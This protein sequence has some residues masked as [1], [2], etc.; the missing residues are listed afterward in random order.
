MK[1][2]ALF[3]LLFTSL[4]FA[5]QSGDVKSS[6][7]VK[8]EVKT[9]DTQSKSE[10]SSEAIVSDEIVMDEVSSEDEIIMDEVSSED[11]IIM[12]EVSSEDEII[13]DEVSSEDDSEGDSEGEGEENPIE[14]MPEQT[15]FVEAV[16]PKEIYSAGVEGSVILEL[17]VNDSGVVDSANVVGSLEPTLDANAAA[18]AL[19]F[20]FTPAVAGGENIPVYIQYE[21]RFSLDDVVQK[22]EE[23][24]NLTGVL[25][26]AG[27]RVA[28][29]DAMVIVDFKDTLGYTGFDVP[30]EMYLKKIGGFEGQDLEEGSIVAITDSLGRFSFKSLPVGLVTLRI[31][32]AGYENY[33]VNE[34]IISGELTDL[35]LRMARLSYNEY[36]VTAYYKGEEKEVS[37]RTLSV[38]E[39]KKIPGLG[40]DAIRVIQ[41]MPGVA[42]PTAG[43]G[44]IVVRGAPSWDS[45]YVLDGTDLPLLYHFGGLKSTYNSEAL[46]TIDFYPGGF[47]TRYGD[48][49]G[50]VVEINTRKAAED[51]W[52]G[53]ADV[54]TL[55]ASFLVEGPVTDKLS[56]MASARRSYFGELMNFGIKHMDLDLGYTVTPFYWDYITRAD[57]TPNDKHHISVSSFG[58]YDSM[59]MV[60]SGEELGNDE[61]NDAANALKNKIFFNKVGATWDWDIN[62]KLKNEMSHSWNYTDMDQSF[63]GFARMKMETHEWSFRN[64]LAYKI[65]DKVLFNGGVDGALSTNDLI[66]KIMDGNGLTQN[67]TTKDWKFGNIGVYGNL[68][69]KPIER[70]LII[71]GIRYDYYRELIHDGTIAPEFNDYGSKNDKGKSGDPSVRLATRFKLNEKHTLKGAVGNYNQSPQPFG[72]AIHKTWGEP[73]LPTTKATHIVLGEEWQITDLLSLDVQGYYNKQWDIPR[74]ADSADYATGVDQPVYH[75]DGEG[76]NYGLEVMLRHNQS[77]RFFGWM[78]YTLSRSERKNPH[79]DEYDLFAQDQTHNLQILGSWKLRKHWETGFRARYT[80]GNPTKSITDKKWD[81]DNDNMQVTY[82][83]YFDERLSP[84]FQL[85][86]RVEKQ[87][88]TPRSIIAIYLDIQNALAPLYSTPE[89][90][91]WDDFYMDKTAFTMPIVPA[92]GFQIKF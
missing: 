51:R 63:F 83:K 88:I 15:K 76:R 21:Y 39:V 73:S 49:V 70:L 38:N 81:T 27:T 31:P 50:G 6:E 9:S 28:I 86:L 40:G 80:T 30:L 35:K 82:N 12:D 75:A 25:Q 26:E 92:L 46:E 90:E 14:K 32:K 37:R 89:F 72:Q 44:E 56:L 34:E 60:I 29:P 16:Y 22:V 58:S 68:E 48:V 78:A 10:Q 13:M 1:R 45:K 5:E 11:E 55:D 66:L 8:D 71:P 24:E 47:G 19:Q 87:F 2:A 7:N 42:R 62:E 77:D 23:F 18:A 84:A 64:N 74:Q 43:G 20:V 3:F 54:S 52:H 59:E 61:M 17:L 33:Q 69:I 91:M 67:D 79:K 4:L 36:E 85:D 65:N 41:A 57:I 53:M